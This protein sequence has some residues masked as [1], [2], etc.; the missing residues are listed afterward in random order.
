MCST[1]CVTASALAALPPWCAA[2][3]GGVTLLLHE[4]PGA[5]QTGI[6]GEHG[7]ALK[8]RLAAPPVDGKANAALLEFLAKSFGVPRTA[9][10]LV[11]GAASRRKRVSVAGAS[12]AEALRCLRAES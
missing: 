11:G 1:R 3:P 8:I 9:V 10:A 5:A 12:V 6:A 7:D 2:G 4:Q